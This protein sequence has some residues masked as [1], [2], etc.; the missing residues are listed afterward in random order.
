MRVQVLGCGDAFGSGGRLHT[1]FHV[2]TGDQQFL[3]DCGASALIAIRR[4]GVDPNAVQTVFLSHL[5]GDHFGG[6]PFLLLDAQFVSRRTT[7]LTIVGPTGSQQRLH[8]LMEAMFPGSAQI[9]RRFSIDLI[10][11]APERP[12]SVH[13]VTVTPFEVPHPSGAPSLAL[14]LE[15]AGHVICYT[16]DTGSVDA[17]IPAARGADL[18]ITEAYTVERQVPYHLT[19]T[20]LRARLGEIGAKRIILTHMSPEM[21]DTSVRIEGAERAED[22]LVIDL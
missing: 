15:S 17:I 6:L 22:G 11:L 4:F 12:R 10:E 16:G 14:R 18:L 13:G 5:H 9:E 2:S 8:N 1:C 20:A 3:I 21:L 7:P 19:W